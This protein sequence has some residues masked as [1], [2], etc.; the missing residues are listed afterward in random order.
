MLG[1]VLAALGR[2]QTDTQDLVDSALASARGEEHAGRDGSNGV[3][4]LK[5]STS[6]TARRA[7][8]AYPIV[9][10]LLFHNESTCFTLRTLKSA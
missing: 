10:R 3:V 4:S 9:K 7:T 5:E 1:G 6:S 2:K 8:V